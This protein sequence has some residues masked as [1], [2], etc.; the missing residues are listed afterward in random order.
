MPCSIRR[1][2]PAARPSAPADVPICVSYRV[3]P[4]LVSHAADHAVF[5]HCLPARRG[6]EV[7]EHVVDG[8]RS[9]VWEQVA[10][11][12]PALQA[13]LYVLVRSGKASTAANS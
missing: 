6:D 8:A 9:L 4:G 3:H 11:R 12:A 5:M 7:S 13:A 1:P 2:D 10:C